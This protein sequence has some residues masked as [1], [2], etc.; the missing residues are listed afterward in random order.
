[1]NVI[2]FQKED[3]NIVVAVFCMSIINLSIVLL[4]K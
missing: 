2:D 4:T 1:M 3:K